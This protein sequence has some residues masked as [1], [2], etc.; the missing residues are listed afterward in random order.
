[1][2]TQDLRIETRAPQPAACIEATTNDI[3]QALAQLLPE[4]FAWVGTHGGE[5]AG[6]PFTRY[7]EI[8]DGSFRIEAGV[9]TATLMTGDNRVRAME[10]P[11]GELAIGN[12]YGPYHTVVETAVALREFLEREGRS[13]SGPLWENYI[14]DPGEVSDQSQLLTGVVYPLS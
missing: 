4:T 9:P 6:A 11:G 12:H 8:G 14:S 7:L 10:L 1:M 2:A 13:A 5:V 3:G